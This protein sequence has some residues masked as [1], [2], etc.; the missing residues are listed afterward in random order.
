MA[1][2]PKGHWAGKVFKGP[3]THGRNSA[4]EELWENYTYFIKQVVPVAEELGMRHRH[5]PG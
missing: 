1:K 3:L 5:S 4:P 2:N